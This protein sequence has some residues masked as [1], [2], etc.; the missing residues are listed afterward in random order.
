MYL[1]PYSSSFFSD[2]LNPHACYTAHPT[3]ISNFFQTKPTI[4]YEN[5]V[6]LLPS[7]HKTAPFRHSAALQTQ[8]CTVSSFCCPPSTKLHRFVILLPSKHETH[9]PPPVPK[10]FPLLRTPNSHFPS[11]YLLHFT[12]L[13]LICSLPLPEG[14][15]G[16]AYKP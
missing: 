13:H 12:T 10:S 4:F 9:P 1:L 5:F 7:K 6:I 15:A 3:L 16:T 11:L 2:C 14:Q 8:N